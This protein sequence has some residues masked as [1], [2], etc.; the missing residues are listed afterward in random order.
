M[1]NAYQ[2]AFVGAAVTFFATTLGALPAVFIK[3][4]SEKTKDLFLGISAGVMLAATA[5]SLVEPSVYLFKEQYPIFLSAVFS[6]LMILFGGL[7]IHVANENIPHVH[8]LGG[9]ENKH[10]STTKLKQIWLFVLAITIHN[11]PEGFAVGTAIGSGNLSISLPVMIGIG[12]QDIPEG[13]VVA[14]AL[15][16]LG[17]SIKDS[18]LVAGI[19]GLVEA[20]AALIG[21][22]AVITIQT[23]LP[24][25]L[26]FAGGMML[27]VISHE[28]IPES[29]KNGF[30]KQA[31]A[32]LMIGFVIMML[33]D[34][35][36][37]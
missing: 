26:A 17:Y 8:F 11:I 18:F 2:M 7:L 19:T 23:L 22:F 21:F 5:F 31:T 9:S 1:S 28:M 15:R 33:L 36:L 30:E 29:H 12:F 4:I 24:W 27:Y 25:T 16:T 3:T 13:L 10:V 34:I 6:G 32:G 14:I 20:I 37:K 35:L